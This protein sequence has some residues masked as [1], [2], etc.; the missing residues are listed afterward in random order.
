MNKRLVLL[1]TLAAVPAALAQFSENPGPTILSRGLGTVMQ[2]GGE[3]IRLRPYF[4]VSGAYENGLIPVSV[5]RFGNLRQ[6][7][8]FGGTAQVGLTGYHTWRRTMLGV[9]YRGDV[10]HYSRGAYYDG[11]D[12]TLTLG[13]TH[14]LSQ[15]LAFTLREAGGTHS[16][17][18][19]I[20]NGYTFFDPSYADVPAN[21]L[22]DGRVYYLSSMGDMTYTPTMRLSFNLGGTEMAVRRRSRALVGMTGYM[23]RGDVQYRL[24]RTVAIGADY[25]FTHYTFTHSFGASDIHTAAFN[26]AF[27]LGRNWDLAIRAGGARVETLGLQRVAVDPIIAA[28]TGVGSG[29]EVFYRMNFLPAGGVKLSRAFR[30]SVISLNAES[31]VSPGNGVYLTS[32]EQSGGFGLSYTASRSLNLG[33]SASY[34]SYSSLAS[35]MGKYSSYNGG[36]GASLRL[37]SWL[38]L[39]ASYSVRKY[40]VRQSAF[41]NRIGHSATVGF[42]VSPGE[43]PLS[44]W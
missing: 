5:D 13:V 8:V 7:S 37:N 15:R 3:L 24:A 25:N 16:R 38:H 27:Q 44:L 31:G 39:V 40:Q 34:S 23:A 42:A 12:H 11:S 26:L 22:F 35:T 33:L 1:V 10:R 18:Y 32:R 21:E 4:A 17:S 14:Q 9:D 30:R 29:V 6:D 36:G 28:I 2:G 41:G 20:Y 43:L 19:G